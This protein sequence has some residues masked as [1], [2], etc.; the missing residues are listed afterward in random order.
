MIGQDDTS[1]RY[2]VAMLHSLDNLRCFLSA[3]RLNSFTRAARENA[4]TP[5]AFGQRIRQLEDQLNAPLFVRT[6]RSVRLTAAGH[7]LRPHAEACLAAAE[8]CRRAVH[9]GVDAP[10]VELVVGTRHELGMSWLLPQLEALAASSPSFSL[11]L[12]VGSG[13]DLLHKT[14]T[15][16]LDCAITSSRFSDAQLDSFQLHKELY[17]MCAAPK[18]LERAPLSRPAHASSHTLLDVAA[19]LPLFQYF[20]DAG[21]EPNDLRFGRVQRLGGIDMIRQRV[22]DGA[23]VAVLP[24][25]VVQGDIR[26]RKL[27]RVFPKVRLQHD[28]FR[29]VFRAGDPRRPLLERLAAEL[30]KR[31]LS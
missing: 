21:S 10:P 18:L 12:Y 11:H 15:L 17:V 23:G 25:Y 20:R 28:F 27:K 7:A 13:Q 29:L 19:E 1:T 26:S 8:R 2:S 22:L 16:E 30:V 3:A 6:T 9:D 31:P 4:L 24:L 5:A 14:R